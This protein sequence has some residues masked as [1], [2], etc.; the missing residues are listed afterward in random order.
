MVTVVGI[1]EVFELEEPA[2]VV[3]AFGLVVV[4]TAFAM[5]VVVAASVS[6][7]D[8][9]RVVARTT[10]AWRCSIVEQPLQRCYDGSFESSEESV[11][12]L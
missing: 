4:V 1:V 12:R 3:M 6:L 9:R 2:E 8:I 11:P 10:T 7:D 5:L